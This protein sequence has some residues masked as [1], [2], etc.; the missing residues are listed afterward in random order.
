[1]KE[2]ITAIITFVGAIG[3][4][5]F[6]LYSLVIGDLRHD[7]YLIVFLLLTESISAIF[8]VI[9]TKFGKI[10]DPELEKI[11]L[12]NEILK[13]QIEKQELLKKLENK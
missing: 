7:D 3:W 4:G 11:E 2:K 5:L 12:E 9:W 1:M 13:K 8:Y 10:K 6:T